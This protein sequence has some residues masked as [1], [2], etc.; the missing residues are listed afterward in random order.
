M[1]I[2]KHGK[3]YGDQ[4]HKLKCPGCGTV[5]ETLT[6]ELKRVTDQRDG[7]YW[8]IPCPVC[9][10]AITKQVPPAVYY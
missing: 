9:P 4:K 7:D 6:S 8:T 1:R 10:R 3:P 5:I 2:V